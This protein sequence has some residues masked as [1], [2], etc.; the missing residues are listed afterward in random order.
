MF[1][2]QVIFETVFIGTLVVH[3]FE[4][5]YAMYRCGRLDLTP[6][7]T[8]KWFINVSFNGVFALKMLHSPEDFGFGLQGQGQPQQKRGKKLH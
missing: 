6:F 2:L 5:F 7:T 1:E 4:L 8:I 3:L